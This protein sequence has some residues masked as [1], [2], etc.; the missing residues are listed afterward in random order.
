[1][2]RQSGQGK[3]GCVLW[4]L[5]FAI[6]ALVAFKMVPIKIKSAELHDFM[7]DQAKWTSRRTGEQVAK[8]VLQKAQEL[9]LPVAEDDVRV[10]IERERIKMDVSYTVPVEF[11]GYTYQWR[12]HHAVDRPIFII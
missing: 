7:V 5:A 6:C 10:V 8:A 12:F 1:M 11:P 3:I 9:D 2:R 4:I